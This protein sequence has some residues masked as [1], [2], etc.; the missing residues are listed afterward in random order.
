[1]KHHGPVNVNTPPSEARLRF[2]DQCVDLKLTTLASN[3]RDLN[4][5]SHC[6]EC[7]A[8]RLSYPAIPVQEW[9][10]LKCIRGN[11]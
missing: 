9:V 4:P 8:L 5:G 1:M 11:V 3:D 7:S 2:N 6:Y 10:R